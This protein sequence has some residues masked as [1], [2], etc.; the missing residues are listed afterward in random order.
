MNLNFKVIVAILGFLLIIEAGFMLLSLIAALIFSEAE[1]TAISIALVITLSAGTFCWFLT[2]K[3]TGMELRKRD[4]YLVVTLSWLVITLFGTLPYLLSGAIPSFSNAFFETTSGFTTTGATILN[5]IEELP[6]C[7]LLWRSLTQWIGGMG[8]IVLAVAILPLLGIGGMQLFVAEAPGISPDKLSPRIKE[9]AKKLWF[10][11]VGLTLSETIM[12]NVAGMGY[13]DA[14]N[15]SF[16]T[17][18]TGGFSTKQA[19]LAA[20]DSP[21]IH[22]IIIGFMFLGGMNFTLIWFGMFGKGKKIYRNEEF[23]TYL[24]AIVGLT[25]IVMLVVFASTHLQI[26]ASFRTALFQVVSIITTTGYVTADYTAWGPFTTVVFFA[27]F[28]VG[29]SAGSTSGG[30]KIVR[31]LVLFKNGFIELK[32]Q[33]HPKAVIPVRLNGKSVH[34]LIVYNIL[35]FMVLYILI[36]VMGT[37]V[38][39]FLGEDIITAMGATAA[40]LGNVGPGIGSVGPVDTYSFIPAA[41]KWFLSIFMIIGRLE[42]FT[43]IILFTSMFWRKE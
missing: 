7:I 31:H 34:D 30:V 43:V 25:T 33:L 15:H 5:N 36:F 39:A 19:S 11:Y 20:W 1:W 28:F 17:L 41:G 18:A 14:L 38:M 26:E 37:M 23:R 12:L 6:K 4:G 10:I 16:T 27:L 22:Y 35:A 40:S 32:R 8:I 21:L 3:N 24:K 9:T 42:L 13:F 2:R 29:A